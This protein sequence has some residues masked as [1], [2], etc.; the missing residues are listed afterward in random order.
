M[1]HSIRRL[2]LKLKK[3]NIASKDLL[4]DLH[5]RTQENIT[6]AEDF[7]HLPFE[8]LNWR[9]TQNSWS[10]LE[11]LEHLNRYGDFYIPEMEK[12]IKSSKSAHSER[13]KSSWLGN[14]FA[15]S[16]LPKEKLKT[17]KT[18][19]SMNPLGSNL[20]V[21]VIS[22]FITQQHLLIDLLNAASKVNLNRTKT[23]ISI[24]KW[25]KLKLGD[26]FRVV[27]YHNQRHISQAEKVLK[28][29][30]TLNNI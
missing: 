23:A 21:D 4:L 18:F 30:N 12:R 5:E 19:K 1:L 6:I 10:I 14:Y 7:K 27:I 29:A 3:M 26:T 24:S 16:M 20:D 9:S 15:N 2:I 13:F 28:K 25:M 22:K 8:T 11:C 17:I